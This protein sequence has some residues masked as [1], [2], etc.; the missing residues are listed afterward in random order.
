MLNTTHTEAGMYA[1]LDASRPDC[2]RGFV[3]SPWHRGASSAGSQPTG[4]VIAKNAKYHHRWP[5][6]TSP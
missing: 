4:L 6:E 3:A 1:V 5:L 2:G